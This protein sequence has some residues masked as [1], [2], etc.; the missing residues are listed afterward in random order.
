MGKSKKPFQANKP[1][2]RPQFQQNQQKQ[3]KPQK[4]VE[5]TKRTTQVDEEF[6]SEDFD[7]DMEDDE[8]EELPDEVDV[9]ALMTKP[10]KPN[11]GK[12]TNQNYSYSYTKPS[13]KSIEDP[14]PAM[15]TQ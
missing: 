14:I 7:Y 4:K 10:L 12:K 9:R 11:F 1:Y 2:K 8:F 3:F 13:E 5:S 15:N 6:S